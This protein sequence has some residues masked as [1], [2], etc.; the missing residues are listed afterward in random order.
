MVIV[1]FLSFLI[2]L[3]KSLISNKGS[4]FGNTENLDIHMILLKCVI[5][6]TDLVIV[7]AKEITSTPAAGREWFNVLMGKRD[8]EF[9]TT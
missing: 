5:N 7:C 6:I 1:A 9:I 2:T 4:K 8:S 3:V